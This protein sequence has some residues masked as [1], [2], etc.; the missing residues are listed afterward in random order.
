MAT[1]A[2]CERPCPK[3]PYFS[4][5]QRLLDG[6]PLG[7]DPCDPLAANNALALEQTMPLVAQLRQAATPPVLV[8]SFAADKLQIEQGESVTLTWDTEGASSVEISG[9]GPVAAKGSVTVTPARSTTYTLTASQ[10]DAL[11]SFHPFSA[12]HP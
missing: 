4:N 8:R 1:E 3:V 6:Q 2:G 9:L 11:P 12:G 10:R 7:I 5:P